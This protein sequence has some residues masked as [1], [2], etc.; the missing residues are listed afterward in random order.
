M[1][2]VKEG[3]MDEWSDGRKEGWMSGV[4]EGRMDEW[5]EGRKDG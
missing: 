5:S 4:M 2:G 1:S 3:R